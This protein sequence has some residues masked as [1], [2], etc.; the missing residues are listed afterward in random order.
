MVHLL[1][2]GLV[3]LAVAC[4]V[5]RRDWARAFLL[6]MAGMVIDLDHLLAQ[7][8]YD[9]G[10]CSIGFHPL[11]SMLPIAIYVAMLAH[12]KTRLLGLG[13]CIHI[14]LDSLDC[15]LTSGV[16]YTAFVEP[17]LLR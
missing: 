1:L 7:P 2:H 15:Q 10:R 16:W 3:P 12:E 11:H 13:L 5:F 4:T 8:I 9:P 17:T 14:T 6:M